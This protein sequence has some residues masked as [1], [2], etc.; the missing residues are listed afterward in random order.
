MHRQGTCSRLRRAP[1]AVMALGLAACTAGVA[2]AQAQSRP[3]VIGIGEYRLAAPAMEQL[4][5]NWIDQLT[6]RYPEHTWAPMRFD[7]SNADLRLMGL[8]SKRVLL[9]HRY[10]VPTAVYP[11]GA[12]RPLASTKRSHS[13]ASG[14]SQSSSSPRGSSRTPASARSAFARARGCCSS[15]ATVWGGAAWRTSTARRAA[16]RSARRDTAARRATRPPSS[17]RWATTRSAGRPCRSCSTS[18]SS[19]SRTAAP[20]TTVTSGTTGRCSRSIRSTRTWSH[21]RWPSGAAPS[22]CTG[23]SATS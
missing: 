19:P 12:M 16:T 7:L 10:R 15:P 14:G 8:P 13:K 5:T 9:S 1:I 17:G 11:N 21:R 2:R 4:R 20:T 3:R 23:R 22:G 6:S 18:A